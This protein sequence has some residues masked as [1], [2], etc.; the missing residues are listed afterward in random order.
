MANAIIGYACRQLTGNPEIADFLNSMCIIKNCL[1]S[2]TTCHLSGC[3]QY[4]RP[5]SLA[6]A[7]IEDV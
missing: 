2:A 6:C 1:I 5:W 4:L 7:R 3:Q